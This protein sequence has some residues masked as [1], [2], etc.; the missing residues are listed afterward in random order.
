MV[1]AAAWWPVRRVSTIGQVTA[2]RW[3]PV[4]TVV[5]RRADAALGTLVIGSSCAI[6]S[7]EM[8]VRWALRGMVAAPWIG[9]PTTWQASAVDLAAAATIAALAM[10][11]VADLHWHAARDRAAESRTLRALGWPA[12][13]FA[14]V[15]A[16]D[17]VWLGSAGGIMSGVAGLAASIASGHQVQPRMLVIGAVAL[18]V[19]VLGSLLAAGAAAAVG[20]YTR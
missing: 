14:R 1:L 13:R 18:V 7:L 20:R 15:A 12:L 3:M 2:A 10:A 19:G 5:D 6:L 4:G 17:A 11:C 8:A 16:W 9:S